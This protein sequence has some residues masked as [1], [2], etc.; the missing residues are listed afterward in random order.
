MNHKHAKTLGQFFKHPISNTIQWHDVIKLLQGLDAELEL[1]KHSGKT[2]VR[3]NDC[4]IILPKQ[5]HKFIASHK[6][7][8]EL[9]H[10]FEQAGLKSS[11]LKN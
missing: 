6:E 7:V 5:T 10:F 8:V 9:R 11:A 1:N 2:I 3:L 4:E